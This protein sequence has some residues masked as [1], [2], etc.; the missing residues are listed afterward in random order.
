MDIT[1]ELIKKFGN[2]TQQGKKKNADSCAA[3]II[4]VWLNG[5]G[6]ETVDTGLRELL[7]LETKNVAKKADCQR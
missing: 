1:K 7:F 4:S 3:A 2:S 6:L 5:V